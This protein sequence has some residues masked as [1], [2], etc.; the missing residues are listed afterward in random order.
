MTWRPSDLW[1]GGV[2]YEGK[3]RGSGLPPCTLPGH[4]DT[5]PGHRPSTVTFVTPHRPGLPGIRP[6]V[7]P[8]RFTRTE[9]ECGQVWGRRRP[10]DGRGMTGQ[11]D[12]IA[13]RRLHA[14]HTARQPRTSQPAGTTDPHDNK[15][16][17]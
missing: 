7:Q 5:R 2:D 12:D 9:C 4:I 10:G 13:V 11:P 15:D 14:T 6:A 1:T 16:T 8:V 17:T 3:R